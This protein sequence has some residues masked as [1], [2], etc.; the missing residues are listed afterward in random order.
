MRHRFTGGGNL[1]GYSRRC[2][3]LAAAPLFQSQ[4]RLPSSLFLGFRPLC[5]GK[6]L[7]PKAPSFQPNSTRQD[8]VAAHPLH[9][10]ANASQF[11]IP[12]LS[13]QYRGILAL[14]VLNHS[15]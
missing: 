12:V 14:T 8:D 13:S 10:G 1:A 9:W 7:A 4:S 15:E 6:A 3:I 11:S 5:R 2:D